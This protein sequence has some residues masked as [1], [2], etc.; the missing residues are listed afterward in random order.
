[1]CSAKPLRRLEGMACRGGFLAPR[2]YAVLLRSL[3]AHKHLSSVFYSALPHRHTQILVEHNTASG[4]VLEFMDSAGVGTVRAAL[5]GPICF[6][7]VTDCL[8]AAVRTCRCEGVN[9]TLETVESV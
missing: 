3:S 2:M 6:D 9:R 5:E 8:T 1:M 4:V 7:S